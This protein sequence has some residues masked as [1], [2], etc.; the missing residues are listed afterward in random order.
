MKASSSERKYDVNTLYIMKKI[1]IFW[2]CEPADPGFPW[3]RDYLQLI[4]TLVPP[5][6]KE[7]PSQRSRSVLAECT[8]LPFHTYCSDLIQ[9]TPGTSTDIN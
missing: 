5:H 9:Y 2:F 4:P 6:K 7:F 8:N 3:V 1:I